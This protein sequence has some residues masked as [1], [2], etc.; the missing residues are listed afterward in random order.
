M[1]WMSS[2]G[3]GTQVAVC[4]AA[5]GAGARRRIGELSPSCS[6]GQ[7]TARHECGASSARCDGRDGQPQCGEAPGVVVAVG[8]GRGRAAAGRAHRRSR[9][10]KEPGIHSGG[11]V[12][13][14][15]GD[16]REHGDLHAV[17]CS[18]AAAVAGASSG[19]VVSLRQGR[20]GGQSGRHAEQELA[21]FLRSVLQGIRGADAVVRG[22]RG[23]EQ[24]PDGEP[25]LAGRRRYGTCAD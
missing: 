24:H 9:A 2:I 19:A 22:R 16:W 4:E 17:E 13:I 6:D 21:A 7:A 11:A 15:T 12:V 25:H 18:A 8:V 23:A 10:G 5:G 14:G 3:M 20:V 1:G